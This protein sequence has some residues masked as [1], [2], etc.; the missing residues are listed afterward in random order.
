MIVAFDGLEIM[1]SRREVKRHGKPVHLTAREFDLLLFMARHADRPFTRMQLLEKVWDI[2]FEG[3]DR[4]VDSHIQRL[5]AKIEDDPGN[6][7]YIRTVWGVGY[8]L[9]SD[10]N[11][12]A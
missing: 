11:S 9:Q 1:P 4:T 6:P 10:A 7:R 12:P 5:R 8:K 2:R 3:Y